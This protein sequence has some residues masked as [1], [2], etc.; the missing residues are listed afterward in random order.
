[1]T[2]K[3]IIE[4]LIERKAAGQIEKIFAN[5]GAKFEKCFFFT[6]YGKTEMDNKTDSDTI[7]FE[8]FGTANGYH[9]T[10]SGYVNEYGSVSVT[11]IWA[12]D[13]GSGRGV[14]VW[15]YGEESPNRFELIGIK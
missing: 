15:C 6:D 8:V 12:S 14:L 10:A 7:L 9:L 2:Y 13:F 3:A 4:N 1:M 11:S 5:S